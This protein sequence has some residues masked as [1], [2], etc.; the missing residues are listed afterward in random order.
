MST[1][2]SFYS[3][4]V[5]YTKTY[6]Q[7]PDCR[8]HV[9]GAYANLARHNMTL[10]VNTIMQAIGMPT[11]NEN[12]ISD[13]FN[14]TH[15]KEIDKLD[16]IKKVLLQERLYR[17]FAFL[18]RMKLEDS[19]KKTVQLNTLLETLSDFTR[20]M[21]YMRN[22]YTHYNPY[23][24][25]DEKGKQRNLNKKMGE[26]LQF[27]LENSLQML[28]DT[29]KLD[30][31]KNEVLSSLRVPERKTIRP[32][33]TEYSNIHDLYFTK[34][35]RKGIK[36][37]KDTKVFTQQVYILN[38]AYSAK[39]TD[40]D[41]YL[42]LAGM[43][44][45]LC[46]FLEKKIAF[47]LMDEVGFTQ[48]CHFNGRDAEQQLL[49][50]K[51]VMCMNRVRMAQPR[52]DS[53][54]SDTALAL[55]MINELRKCPEPLFK[56]LDK[57]ARNEFKDDATVQWEMEHNEEARPG[58]DAENDNNE[59]DIEE[60]DETIWEDKAVP[61]ST[62][63][64][65][66]DRFPQ[67][68]LSYIDMQ[69]V[70]PTIRFQLNLG[71]Y[72]FAFYEHDKEYSVDNAERLR[73][74]QKEMHG[75]G[76]PQEVKAKLKEKWKDYFEHKTIENGLTMK[77]PDKAGQAPYV[78]EQNPQ[79]AIDEKSHSI[80]LRWGEWRGDHNDKVHYCDL[81]DK[82]MFIPYL[83]NIGATENNDRQQNR[84]EKLLPP[85]CMLS[86]Y[87]L[88][89]LVFYHYLL[90]K[91]GKDNELVEKQI[92]SCHDNLVK[93]LTDV[94]DGKFNPDTDGEGAKSRLESKLMET[95]SL[96][97]SDI[98]E[99]I[100]K[101]LLNETKSR[102]ERLKKS[103]IKRLEKRSG[104]VKIAL[105]S[106]RT[107]KKRIG[108]KENKFN[109][110]RS[111]IK[112]GTLAL[113]LMR[114]IMDWM[115]RG[116][117]ARKRLSGES[118]MALQAALTMLGQSFGGKA[119]KV[120]VDSLEEMLTKAKL[121]APLDDGKSGNVKIVEFDPMQCHP[122]MDDVLNGCYEDTSLED[123]Y[124]LYLKMEIKY[125]RDLIKRINKPLSASSQMKQYNLIPFLH[126]GRERWNEVDD[127]AI[128][129][130]AEK[131]LN[132]PIQLPNS[133]FA[134]PIFGLLEDV[135]RENNLDRLSQALQRV[136][137]DTH[138]LNN[139][140]AYLIGLYF[141][142]VEGD[143]SQAFYNSFPDEDGTTS[144]YRHVYQVFKK[145]YG[146]P[147]W[148]TNQTTTPAYSKK[149]ISDILADRAV[150]G[151]MLSDRISR[152][153]Q[154]TVDEF[155][156]QKDDD[157]KQYRIEIKDA[158]FNENRVKHLR[159]KAYEIFEQVDVKVAEKREEFERLTE[160]YR[161][162]V[163]AKLKKLLKKVQLNERAI[164]RFKTQD[165]L[166]LM[167]SR[168]I[169]KMGR[170]NEFKLENVLSESLLE[171]RVDFSWKVS[172]NDKTKDNASTF[173]TIEQKNMKM[174]DY[175]HFYKFASD[176][177]R[178]ESLLSRLSPS[179]FQRA[180]IENEFS[181]YDSNRSEVFRL[182]YILESFALEMKPGLK[183][184]NNAKEPWFNYIRK[185]K[186]SPK[187]NSFIELL[188]VLIAGADGILDNQE[189]E[190]LREIRNAFGHNTYDVDFETV[191]S[192][193]RKSKRKVPE[194]ANGIKDNM[195]DETTK[196]LRKTKK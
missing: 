91:Y 194:V 38:P 30:H 103:S 7:Q 59:N 119:L 78:T 143:H 121:I 62:F 51:E 19:K 56:V 80:G 9:F 135:A 107:K 115:P 142:L 159:K 76:R 66:N 109:R 178:L 96:R 124:E 127:A 179:V 167:M 68:T 35:K 177:Q 11:F 113:D 148:G 23:N 144:P 163:E 90:K 161:Q 128:K 83:P 61:R 125:I 181:Y 176:H 114:D 180:E 79:Y 146:E 122:F 39:M 33:D 131:Y 126:C 158:A 26:C 184:D 141:E 2:D 166:L 44:H 186:P 24:S 73:V 3:F 157:L 63:V 88:P 154:K 172:V 85:K 54:M 36:Y 25:D 120:T 188:E 43:V 8:R 40:S 45:F 155:K 49:Y 132:S 82:Y 53:E 152:Y 28:K 100:K 6:D 70:L 150:N 104:E 138:N 50:I 16:N 17:H 93:F 32:G 112:T 48:Q 149:E 1:S 72:R 169:L 196:V 14:S 105:D 111:T 89:G 13:A 95:Y 164:L 34:N 27:L 102:E 77:E 94:K 86:L 118:Y 192:G 5:D 58:E 189:K 69:S 183:D 160:Q 47:E 21:A 31:A 42:S 84:A 162:E 37:D 185:G 20:M 191:F 133:L 81:D 129:K 101:Y 171:K 173:K 98:P 195:E 137:Q 187:R 67:M 174:K 153:V 99:R 140:T 108:T 168:D 71:K 74:L 110:K 75:F 4:G 117:E 156:K 193:P 151:K 57:E 87:E 92:I 170:D 147:I 55:D 139:N 10:V 60:P 15:R 175:G 52:L 130:L 134:K 97:L 12:K 29:E 116:C 64:R 65:W 22:F 182:V 190:L 123:F 145:L 165:I 41:G 18:K 136:A 106:Y 46:L